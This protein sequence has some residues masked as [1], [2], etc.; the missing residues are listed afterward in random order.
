MFVKIITVCATVILFLAIRAVFA[1]ESV[2]HLLGY[3]H[4]SIHLNEL[5]W[6]SLMVI[7]V[8]IIFS[9]IKI[10]KDRNKYS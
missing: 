2:D 4:E 5:I 6:I 1:H 3:V 8:F 7:S 9:L 10:I